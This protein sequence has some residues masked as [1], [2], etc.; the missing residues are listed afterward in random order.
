MPTPPDLPV[1]PT[2]DFHLDLQCN[3]PSPTKPMNLMETIQFAGAT[4]QCIELENLK[5]QQTIAKAA[6]DQAHASAVP[7]PFIRQFQ[8]LVVGIVGFVGV[9]ITLMV[10]AV[11]ARRQQDRAIRHQTNTLR[12]ALRAE[13]EIIRE[14]FLDRIEAI[15]EAETNTRTRSMLI[16][17]D[18]MTDVY[19]QLIDQIGLLSRKETA[20]V[21]RAYILIRQM[22]QRIE[23]L[24]KQHATEVEKA[25]GFAEVDGDLFAAV[26]T[27]HENYLADIDGAITALT[28]AV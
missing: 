14:A 12:V 7:T 10:N 11:L 17:L 25:R 16:P 2:P 3:P 23:L 18:T 24:S 5:V 1:T 4:H 19:T 8:T 20:A 26:K 27:M 21:V 9:V 15:K 28:S 13:L 22:P 6:V